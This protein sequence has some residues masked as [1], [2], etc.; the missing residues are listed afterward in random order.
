M[1]SAGGEAG[2]GGVR[3]GRK[4]RCARPLI[5]LDA[6]KPGDVRKTMFKIFQELR[7][8]VLPLGLLSLV[9][10]QTGVAQDGDALRALYMEFL[11][12]EGFRPEVD[13]D[14]DVV[15]K[16][17][18]KTYFVDVHDTDAEFFM[19][20]LPN[21]WPIESEKE[22]LQVLVAADGVNREAKAAKVSTKG[23][24]VWITLEMFVKNPNDFRGVFTRSMSSIDTAVE[25]FVEKMRE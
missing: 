16:Y 19:I 15:F 1:G 5:S 12:G 25:L 20:A 18:G 8:W 23:D 21:I 4:G 6:E 24:N 14:G 3:E 13:K 10:V 22:R 2:T 7:L 9:A 11:S 17:E